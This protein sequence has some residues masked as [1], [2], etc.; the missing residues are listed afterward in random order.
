M[1]YIINRVARKSLTIYIL[2]YSMHRKITSFIIF[3]NII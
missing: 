2:G 3:N 1:L